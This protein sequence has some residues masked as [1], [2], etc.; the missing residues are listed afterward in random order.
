MLK[1]LVPRSLFGTTRTERTQLPL[2]LIDGALPRDLSG[3]L[4]VVA[5]A[6]T[7]RPEESGMQTT[8]MVGD[9]LVTRFDLSPRSV[10]LTSRLMRT[11]DFV[12][13][14]I[15]SNDR[16]LELFRFVSAGL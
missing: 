11:H 10:S 7:F 16:S 6:G 12:A 5:P 3:H 15:T 14:E 8:L 1:P 13:D 2:D 9:G 4:F